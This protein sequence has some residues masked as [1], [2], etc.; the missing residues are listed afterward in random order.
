MM[1]LILVV[2]VVLAG[3]EQIYETFV[4]GQRKE[5]GKLKGERWTIFGMGSIHILTFLATLFEYFALRK[6][7]NY[8]ISFIGL[9]MYLVG[10]IGRYW[11]INAL[12]RFWS[13]QIEIRD[14]HKLITNGPYNLMRHPAYF[15]LFFKVPAI[16]LILNSY[17]TFYL[18]LL[19]YCPLVLI[20]LYCEEIEMFKK[21]GRSYV[22]F[23]KGKW[24]LF[25]F[26]KG[27]FAAS[28]GEW[29]LMRKIINRW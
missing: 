20:R 22:R 14:K 9:S 13:V 27:E 12:G 25:P 5:K 7:L 23:R 6:S 17:Y 1:P 16:P 18:V 29:G 10:I 28:V 3:L 4:L 8:Y 2:I 21:F 15:S 19:A 26:P 24:A 11:S